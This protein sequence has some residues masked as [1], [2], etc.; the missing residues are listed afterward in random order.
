MRI[1]YLIEEVPLTPDG[2]GGTSALF[3]GHLSLLASSGHE[4]VLGLISNPQSIQLFEKYCVRQQA[5]WKQVCA[6]TSSVE[7]LSLKP[8]AARP[9]RVALVKSAWQLPASYVDPFIYG[10]NVVALREFVNRL[11]PD[12][13]VTGCAQPGLLCR[14]A[15]LGKSMVYLHADWRFRIKSLRAGAGARSLNSRFRYWQM[16]RAEIDLVRGARATLCVS[17]TEAREVLG[18]GAPLVGYCPT[19]Y[20]PVEAPGHAPAGAP[21]L[22][23]LGGMNTTATHQGLER[24]FEI[25]WPRLKALMPE[26]PELWIVGDTTAASPGLRRQ[27]EQPGVVCTGFVQNLDDV[28]RPYDIH[29]IPW[30]HATGTR[31]R[32]AIAL[33]YAQV[34]VTPRLA[35][36]PSPEIRNGRDCVLVPSL[37]EMAPAINALCQNVE[38]RKSI[39]DAARATFLR[40][41]THEAQ[42]KPFHAFLEACLAGRTDK[43]LWSC[44]LPTEA[45][46]QQEAVA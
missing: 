21:R 34:V 22:M 36:A 11:K 18:L 6:W 30:E 23:H 40:C 3:Y 5:D 13:I 24:F 16:R 29:V 4:V 35:A 8:R 33:N 25:V 26:M 37:E 32:M 7:R 27:M 45:W 19:S 12:L 20:R 15:G 38:L 14:A 42:E 43:K 39:G 10:D 9:S 2:F 17:A 41:F 28:M 1:L 44:T 46:Q 31:T